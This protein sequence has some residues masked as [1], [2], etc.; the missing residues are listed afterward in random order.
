[1]KLPFSDRFCYFPSLFW[2]NSKF[3]SSYSHL[4]VVGVRVYGQSFEIYR[5]HIFD[6]LSKKRNKL[7]LREETR[8]KFKVDNLSRTE[9]V[10]IADVTEFIRMSLENR[11]AHSNQLNQRSSR[12]HALF[13]IQFE[14]EFEE[15]KKQESET[16]LSSQD[17]I[18][19]NDISS[20]MEN[21]EALVTFSRSQKCRSLHREKGVKQLNSRFKCQSTL[22]ESGVSKFQRKSFRNDLKQ[23]ANESKKFKSGSSNQKRFFIQKCI[24]IVDLA[25]SERLNKTKNKGIHLQEANS[26]NQSLSCLGRCIEALKKNIHVPYRESKLT[27][28]LSQYFLQKNSISMIAHMNPRH[29][30]FNETLRVLSYANLASEIDPVKS[31]MMVK[32][33]KG[34][35]FTSRKFPGRVHTS[36]TKSSKIEKFISN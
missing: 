29:S 16:I 22:G 19:V 3:V 27:K 23:L 31:T 30:D 20:E 1:M 2:Q 15:V 25:G 33:T 17:S 14:F 13:K 35:L 8:N 18:N 6:L 21:H 24:N 11:K 7:K 36:A 10:N 5:K 4:K 28:F 9:I 34:F 32:N 12:S 26:V